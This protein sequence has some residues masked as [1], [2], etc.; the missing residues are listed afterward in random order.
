M[1]IHQGLSLAVPLC[2][3]ILTVASAVTF[4]F[5]IDQHWNVVQDLF[6]CGLLQTFFSHAHFQNYQTRKMFI[7]V[8]VV[9]FS[10]AWLPLQGKFFC[11]KLV[12][13]YYN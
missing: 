12:L 7:A 11:S 4:I 13:T 5:T 8:G 3:F 10:V 6:D 9:V 1:A 2:K